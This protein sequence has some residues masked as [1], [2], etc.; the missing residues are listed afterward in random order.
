MT[1]V[2]PP[3]DRSNRQ[4]ARS[5]ASATTS[6]IGTRQRYSTA[7]TLISGSGAPS[8]ARRPRRPGDLDV[9][10]FGVAQVG[11]DV[12]VVAGRIG[13]GV[14]EAGQVGRDGSR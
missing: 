6:P 7:G 12:D 2:Q 11:R 5:R 10:V 8:V 13:R 9:K 14:E 1:R 4:T 3:A